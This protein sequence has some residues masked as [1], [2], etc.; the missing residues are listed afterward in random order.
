VWLLAALS[1]CTGAS[2]CVQVPISNAGYATLAV[3]DSSV[4]ALAA[5]PG[6]PFLANRLMPART[7][8]S[9]LTAT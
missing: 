6:Y 9:T 2:T 5:N 4:A 1:N 3:L 7:G 8:T